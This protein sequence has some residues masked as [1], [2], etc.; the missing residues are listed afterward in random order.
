MLPPDFSFSQQNLQDYLDCKRRFYLRYIEHLEWPAIESEPVLEQEKLMELGHTFHVLVQQSLSGIPAE[1]IQAALHDEELER[2]WRN[3]QALDLNLGDRSYYVE[4]MLS[5]PFS[6]FRLIA[7]VDLVVV[8]EDQSILI[9]DWKT[10]RRVPNREALMR[11][12]QSKVYPFVVTVSSQTLTLSDPVDP[13]NIKMIYWFPEHPLLPVEMEYSAA[14]FEKDEKELTRLITEINSLDGR[15]EFPK[16]DN[17]R[18]CEFCS[19]RSF[20]GRGSS[21]GSSDEEVLTPS[22]SDENPFEIDF[23]SL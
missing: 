12:A 4:E 20:C 10:S 17:L 15:E 3:F 8:L 22:G 18:L 19:F 6:G 5:I 2:W 1:S 7:K 23:E 14:K 16:T 9:Y 21:A 11:R 13:E